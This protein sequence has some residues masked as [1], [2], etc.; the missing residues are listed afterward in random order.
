[1]STLHC[2]ITHFHLFD[3]ED[4]ETG[5]ARDS[6]HRLE[7]LAKL[8]AEHLPL[9]REQSDFLRDL[10]PREYGRAQDKNAVAH[11]WSLQTEGAHGERGILR[12]QVFHDRSRLVELSYSPPREGTWI[13]ESSAFSQESVLMDE[14]QK[15]ADPNGGKAIAAKLLARLRAS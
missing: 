13:D 3:E 9:T 11:I 15:S 8:A 7:V 6:A 12:V 5:D 10:M 14:P 4:L 2:E 1:M